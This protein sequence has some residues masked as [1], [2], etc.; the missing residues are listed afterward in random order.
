MKLGALILILAIILGGLVGGLV[1]DDPG[2]VL[3]AYGDSALE[4]SLWF[5]A[6]LLIGLYFLIRLAVVGF[7]RTMA[8][9][10]RLSSWVR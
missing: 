1:G 9:S 7:T 4:T 5:A 2:Y 6:I 3:L 8:G 10:G